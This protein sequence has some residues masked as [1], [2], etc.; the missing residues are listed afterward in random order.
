VIIGQKH[1][2]EAAAVMF[3][4]DEVYLNLKRYQIK[5]SYKINTN[6]RSKISKGEINL[7]GEEFASANRCT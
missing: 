1:L 3:E 5:D 2:H 4:H 6:Q 7:Y